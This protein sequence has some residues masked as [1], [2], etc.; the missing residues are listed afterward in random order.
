MLTLLDDRIFLLTLALYVSVIAGG[1]YSL[2]R[3]LGLDR[4]GRFLRTLLQ[5]AGKRLNRAQRSAAVRQGRG[6]FFAAFCSLAAW[7]TGCALHAL[8]ESHTVFYGLEVVVL[9]CVLPIRPAYEVTRRMVRRLKAGALLEARV[10]AMVFAGREAERRDA[11]GLIRSALEFLAMAFSRRLV[12]PALWYI[13]LGLP[14]ALV[15][16]FLERFSSLHD[17]EDPAQ[18]AFARW[19]VLSDEALQ[20]LPSWLSSCLLLLAS[21]V[22]PGTSIRRAMAVLMQEGDRAPVQVMAG[23]LG[24]TL[25]GPRRVA[26]KILRQQWVGEGS[27]KVGPGDLARGQMLY[28]VAC[29]L[30][31]LG[32]SLF[33]I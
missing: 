8:A 12:A 32:M 10:I 7:L 20:I 19:P 4:P 29:A 26:G 28:A 3:F 33:H 2:H 14:G 30:M 1:P 22:V 31:V 16:T 11:H 27:A 24:V 23:A 6:L 17:P 21:P 15:V 25:G 9:A 13:V 18:S 5:T